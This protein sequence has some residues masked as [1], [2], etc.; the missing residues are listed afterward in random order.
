[1]S[2]QLEHRPLDPSGPVRISSYEGSTLQEAVRAGGVRQAQPLLYEQ[3]RYT[4]YAYGYAYPHPG[5]YYGMSL[6]W[7]YPPP[8]TSG[9]WPTVPRYYYW[10]PG[11]VIIHKKHPGHHHK[12]HAHSSASTEVRVTR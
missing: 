11:K 5:G 2:P 6:N 3:P 10:F 7:G 9:Y 1:D 12:H 4:N 8:I